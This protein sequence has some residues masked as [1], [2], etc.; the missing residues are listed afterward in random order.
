MARTAHHRHLHP[1]RPRHRSSGRR[2]VYGY[3]T[4][5]LGLLS[6]GFL[7]RYSAGGT[8]ESGHGYAASGRVSIG[9]TVTAGCSR[10]RVIEQRLAN[11]V[12]PAI[13][14]ALSVVLCDELGG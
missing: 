3:V 12:L 8:G 10:S 6:C 7:D 4:A 9:L 11:L 13:T 2:W 1:A 14:T 5:A